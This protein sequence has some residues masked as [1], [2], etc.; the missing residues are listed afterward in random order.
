[1]KKPGADGKAILFDFGGTLDG[2]GIHWP[3]R[4]HIA[5]RAVGGTLGRREF[6]ALFHTTDQDLAE[7]PGIRAMGMRA[8]IAAQAALLVERL[9]DGATINIVR[10]I[11]SLYESVTVTV[12]RNRPMLARLAKRYKLGVVSNFTGNL[13]PCL[14]ELGLRPLFSALADSTLI[15]VAKP[16]PAVF[17]AALAE[18]GVEPAAAWM[19]GDNPDADIR[20]AAALGMRTI[21]LASEGRHAP[22]GLKPTQRVAR[23]T[24]IEPYLD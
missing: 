12:A 16:D 2:D 13:E 11:E 14:V 17:T 19:V 10:I 24:E 5:Y 4:F 1:V 7:L 23:L 20:P 15:G 9:P 8:A 6:E 21:W 22:P 3:L 18:L